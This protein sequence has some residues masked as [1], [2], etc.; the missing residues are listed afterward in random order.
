MKNILVLIHDDPGQEARLQAALDL[1]RALRGHLTCLDVVQL[2]VPAG[3][4]LGAAGAALMLED[5]EAREAEN[6]ARL[7]QR[8]ASEDVTW[9]MCQNT[10]DIADCIEASSGLADIIVANTRLE[11]EAAPHMPS[12]VSNIVLRLHK[13]VLA[14]PQDWQRLD[15]T[16]TVVIGWDG[17]LPAMAALTGAI[18]LLKLAGSV[19]IIQVGEHDCAATVE[20]AAVYLSRHGIQPEVKHIGE[21]DRRPDDI[22]VEQA[23]RLNAAYAVIGAYGHSQ[24]REMVFGGVTRR[25]LERAEIPLLLAH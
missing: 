17:S 15:A 2:A 16:G 21:D 7:M 8:L 14:M 12:I 6:R 1:T 4:Y 13:P 3:D 18:P 11:D 23:R 24:L 20:E 19:H 10:G 25:M 9:N 5:S 22:I